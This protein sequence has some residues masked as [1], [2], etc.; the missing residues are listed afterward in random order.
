M[1]LFI[2]SKGRSKKSTTL[3]QLAPVLSVETKY[4]LTIVVPQDEVNDY[5]I[6]LGRY[7]EKYGP[8]FQ[9]NVTVAGTSVVG[10]AETRKVCASIAKMQGHAKFAMFDDD[11]IFSRRTTPLN[12]K[13]IPLGDGDAL[14]MLDA[15]DE[16]LDYYHHASIS[17][18]PLNNRIEEFPYQENTRLLRV[19]AYQ[20]DTFLDC[21]HGRVPVMEDFDVTL[22]LLRKGFANANLVMWS[23]DQA[24]TQ[25]AGGCSTY[26]THEMQ[27]EAAKKL[28]ELHPG[29]VRLKQKA[30]KTGGD[31]GTR[32]DVTI[33]WKKAF[34]KSAEDTL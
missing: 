12:T 14:T 27:E 9:A 5:N 25:A 10:I 19:L 22:Q 29:L 24:A 31:F 18:R 17:I 13:L 30:N 32:T 11:L 6:M 23:Q 8:I 7:I 26:R 3:E 21:E 33:S 20:T 2:P 28:A 4:D 1:M 15:L 34:D 16:A